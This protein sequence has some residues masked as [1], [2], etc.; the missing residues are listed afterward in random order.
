MAMYEA[1]LRSAAAGTPVRLAAVG[2]PGPARPVDAAGWCGPARPGDRA[3]L[4]RCDG[5]TLD[6][7]CGPGRLLAQLPPGALGIDLSATAVRMAR[8]RG[9]PALRRDVFGPLP[10]EGRWD[11][12]VLADG[13]IGIGGDPA[14]LLA[15]CR[16]LLHRA[17]RLVVE[18]DPPGRASWSGRLR[19]RA[20]GRVS[21][22][23]RWAYVGVDDIAAIGDAAA[24]RTLAVF[25]E[26]GRWFATLAP[27]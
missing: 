24:L 18:V 23:F 1:A 12:V 20:G 8:R 3:L 19:L 11:R 17:G 21:A 9:A 7:G 6:V 16:T 26:A 22:P 10:A 15:R 25:A 2:G 14:P 13:N 27:A 5:A 4:A